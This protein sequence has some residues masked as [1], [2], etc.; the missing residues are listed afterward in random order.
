MVNVTKEGDIAMRRMT[1]LDTQQTSPPLSRMIAAVAVA[2]LPFFGGCASIPDVTINYRPVKWTLLVTVAHTITC[3]RDSTVAIVERGA[4]FT[5]IYSAAPIDSRYQI[6]LK[7]LDRFFADTDI[8]ISLTDDGRLKSINQATT[9]QG[10][11]IVKSAIAAVATVSAQPLTTLQ[12]LQPKAGVSLF[13]QNVFEQQAKEAKP[14][15]VCGI[16]SKYRVAAADKLPQVSLVQTALV[17]AASGNSVNAKPSKDQEALLD[18]LRAAALD[19]RIEVTTGLGKE[20]LQPIAK[21]ADTVSRDEVPLALQRMVSLSTSVK[22]VQGTIGS[23]SIPVATTDI[24]VVPIPKAAL[25]GK[26]SFSVTLAESGRITNIGYGR[27][28][29]VPGALGAVT[30]VAG[31]ETTE[32]NIEAAA[33]K[34]AA[35]LIAQQQRYNN[36][37][38]KPSECK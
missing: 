11:T 6:K 27:T 1:L 2:T 34:A 20:E 29:G 30:A 23:K 26:Q 28:T 31:A 4:T 35:D 24:F 14:T 15:T 8:A 32:D 12:A 19:L 13:R 18:E 38:L 25:F 22:D 7:D 21:L 17:N 5:P 10:E 36:C 9:G 16:V 33:M 37:K 3:N